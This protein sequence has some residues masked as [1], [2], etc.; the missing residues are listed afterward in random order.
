MPQNQHSIDDLTYEFDYNLLKS[1]LRD[2]KHP[3]VKINQLIKSQQ[4][5]RVKKGIYVKTGQSYS[6]LVLANMIYGPSYISQDFALALY[7]LIPERVSTVTSMTTGRHKEFATPCGNFSYEH[8]ALRVYPH[9]IRRVEIEGGRAYLI[10]SPEKALVDRIWTIKGLDTL[11]KLED[12]LEADMRFD[13]ANIKQI[14]ISSL[15][16]LADVYDVPVIYLL[17]HLLRAR[18]AS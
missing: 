4:I 1:S 17:E 2:Y 9:G 10:A 5:I 11:K 15:K 6:P 8:L 7:G 14:K 18:T 16:K 12:Y 13:F 3:R